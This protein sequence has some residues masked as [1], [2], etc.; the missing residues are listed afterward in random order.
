M[1]AQLILKKESMRSLQKIVNRLRVERWA[2][3][4]SGKGSMRYQR[5]KKDLTQALTKKIE[6][7]RTEKNGTSEPFKVL[8]W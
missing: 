8:N 3:R 7:S 2:L 5:E 1:E 4:P 6:N